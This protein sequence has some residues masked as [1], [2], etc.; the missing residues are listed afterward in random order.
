M[1]PRV[2][3]C[4][5]CIRPAE[6]NGCTDPSFPHGWD[7]SRRQMFSLC[8]HKDPTVSSYQARF[9]KQV[10][11][12]LCMTGSID[13]MKNPWKSE[14]FRE[15]VFFCLF[16][17]VISRYPSIAPPPPPP[18][19]SYY[20]C[21]QACVLQ[22]VFCAPPSPIVLRLRVS[23]SAYLSVLQSRPPPRHRSRVYYSLQ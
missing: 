17:N 10:A 4:L 9:Q 8:L 3:H 22:N 20:G 14:P 2:T 18:E 12:F 21:E 16:Q 5:V 13:G 11:H 7:S 1:F 19:L 15:D 23:S 6:D